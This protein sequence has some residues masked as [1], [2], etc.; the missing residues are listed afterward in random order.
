MEIALFEEG[1]RLEISTLKKNISKHRWPN[2]LSLGHF[3]VLEGA[4]KW[5]NE[6]LEDPL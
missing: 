1:K 3:E 4:T 5:Q 6:S 2:K